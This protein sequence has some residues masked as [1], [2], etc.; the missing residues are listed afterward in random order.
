MFSFKLKLYEDCFDSK[1]AEIFLM[2]KNENYIIDLKLEKK[3]SYDLLYAFLKKKFQVLRN[4]LLENFALNRIREFFNFVKILMLFVFKKNNNLQLCV[5]YR[6]L[7]VVIIKNKCFFFQ[8]KET[9]NRLM[10]AVNFTKFNFKNVYHRIRIRKNNEWI[11][12]FRTRY[13]H[14]KYIMMSFNLINI[15]TMF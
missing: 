1:N 11:I 15:S 6:S 14:F 8:I 10:N 9:F 4:Y 7:N 3:S 2:H 13:D 5:N 12:V